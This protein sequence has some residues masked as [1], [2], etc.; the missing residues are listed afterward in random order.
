MTSRAEAPICCRFCTRSSTVAPCFK[1][2][3]LTGLSCA[4]TWVCR[5]TSVDPPE[6]GPGCETWSSLTTLT[7]SPPCR[8]ET[9]CSRTSPP[10]TTVPVRSLTTTLARG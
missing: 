3:W 2:M 1:S 5:T 9:G 10:I 6:N 7:V 4:C 8:I